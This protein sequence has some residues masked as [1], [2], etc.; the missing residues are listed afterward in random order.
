[1]MKVKRKFWSK[2]GLRLKSKWK[3][4]FVGVIALL[5]G[6]VGSFGKNYD[7]K[8]KSV[9]I[10]ILIIGLGWILNLILDYRKSTKK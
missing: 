6:I 3:E 5:F 7:V 2:E 1:M 10:F 8:T 4:I 9:S